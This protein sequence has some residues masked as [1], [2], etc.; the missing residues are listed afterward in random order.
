M[1]SSII[2]DN[3]WNGKKVLQLCHGE[4]HNEDRRWLRNAWKSL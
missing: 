4:L 3:V 1:D 2:E